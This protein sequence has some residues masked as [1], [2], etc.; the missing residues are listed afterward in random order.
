MSPVSLWATLGT[1]I[2][3][4]DVIGLPVR[5]GLNTREAVDAGN[6]RVSR[7]VAKDRMR[8]TEYFSFKKAMPITL[9][10]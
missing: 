7:R 6:F 9:A 4:K 5:E 2:R 10:S 3:C 8:K 1:F